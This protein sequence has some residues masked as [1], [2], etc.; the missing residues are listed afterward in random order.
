[1]FSRLNVFNALFTFKINCCKSRSICIKV[2]KVKERLYKHS[3]FKRQE[4]A[5]NVWSL[6]ESYIQRRNGVR[7]T[8]RLAIR[9]L[10]RNCI[11]LNVNCTSDSIM[12]EYMP[13]LPVLITSLCCVKEYPHSQEIHN[14]VSL[15]KGGIAE[16]K[17][18]G[19]IV[20]TDESR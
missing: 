1:M 5:W 4:K 15:T 8:D 11:N 19:K 20:P 6:I 7:E 12:Y 10:L 9:T 16:A 3:R 14:K 2:I 13:H 17:Q 18:T